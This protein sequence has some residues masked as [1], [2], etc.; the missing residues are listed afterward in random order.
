MSG[1]NLKEKVEHLN[2]DKIDIQ[3]IIYIYCCDTFVTDSHT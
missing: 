1:Q 3:A 2:G